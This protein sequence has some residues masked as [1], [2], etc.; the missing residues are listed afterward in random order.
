MMSALNLFDPA[1]PLVDLEEADLRS[2]AAFN[3]A[4]ARVTGPLS[5]LPEGHEQR[6]MNGTWGDNAPDHY[7]TSGVALVERAVNGQLNWVRK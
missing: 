1:Y 2:S 6:F 7:P 5:A 3:A 4:M